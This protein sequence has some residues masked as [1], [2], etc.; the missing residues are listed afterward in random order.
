MRSTSLRALRTSS[1]IS[2]RPR[3][4]CFA[5]PMWPETNRSSQYV[6]GI[7]CA[8]CTILWSSLLVSIGGKRHGAT[9][10]LF[11]LVILVLK[12][13]FVLG[14]QFVLCRIARRLPDSSP[15]AISVASTFEQE[16]KPSATESHYAWL[17]KQTVPSAT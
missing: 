13:I 8:G 14:H 10:I 16:R 11:W 5:S 9:G 12:V 3:V 15:V 7:P 2:S 1:G 17:W 6:A 4:T